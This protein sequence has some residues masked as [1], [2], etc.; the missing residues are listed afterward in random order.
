MYLPNLL[1]MVGVLLGAITTVYL[2]KDLP[3]KGTPYSSKQKLM[4]IPL[5][6]G[7][8]CLLAATFLLYSRR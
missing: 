6:L 4:M 3:P 1:M 2:M 7:I 8:C 5:G